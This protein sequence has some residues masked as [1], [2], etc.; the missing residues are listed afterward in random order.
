MPFWWVSE[1]YENLWIADEPAAYTTSLGERIAFRLDYKQRDVRTSQPQKIPAT[2]LH[3]GWFSYVHVRS[4]GGDEAG[5]PF[6]W[7]DATVFAR[8]GGEYYFADWSPVDATTGL[9]LMPM[10]GFS[11]DIYPN[12][13]SPSSANVYGKVGFRLV[14]PD[15]SQDLYGILTPKYEDTIEQ[16]TWVVGTSQG[17]DASLPIRLTNQVPIGAACDALLSEH[18]DPNGNSIHFIYTNDAAQN[19]LLSAVVDYD[20]LTTSLSYANVAGTNLLTQVEMPYGRTVTISY[21]D[22]IKIYDA[23]GMH[24]TITYGSDGYVNSL[25]TPYGLTSFSYI[26]HKG[27]QAGLDVGNAGATNR[28]SRAVLVTHPDNSQELFAYRWDS[29][30]AG[31]AEHMPYP[32]DTPLS[33]LD[34]GYDTDTNAPAACYYRNTFHWD[35]KQFAASAGPTN[36]DYAHWTATNYAYAAVKHWLLTTNKPGFT[37][38]RMYVGTYRVSSAL[39]W[40]REASPSGTTNQPGQMVWYDYFDKDPDATWRI[41]PSSQ[42]LGSARLLPDGSSRYRQI[43]YDFMYLPSTWS[44]T[45]TLPG[46]TRGVR[47]T[48]YTRDFPYASETCVPFSGNVTNTAAATTLSWPIAML[49]AVTGPDSQTLLALS[50]QLDYITNTV[51]RSADNTNYLFTTVYPHRLRV[52]ITDAAGN[53]ATVW[54][55]SQGRVTGV[56]LPNGLTQT[57]K[58]LFRFRQRT[59]GPQR[60]EHGPGRRQPKLFPHK[61]PGLHQRP[62]LAGHQRTWPGPQ[63]QLGQPRTAHESR[64]PARYR[65]AHCK[66]VRQAGPGRAAG[67]QGQF[68]VGQLQCFG[69][70]RLVHRQAGHRAHDSRL[71]QLRWPQFHHR[72][73]RR[74]DQLRARQ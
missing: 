58:Y 14:Y 48:A 23:E 1:P 4:T 63:V 35:R 3:H 42:L 68:L 46:G 73:G 72:P 69:P 22:G 38:D 41:F 20:G 28:I 67:S 51:L 31:L 17:D 21:E 54:S 65:P 34:T 49:S 56:Q 55:D 10:D 66:H 26:D 8:D 57:N 7:W 11:T 45:Y 61:H 37:S 18:V 27:V 50:S 47:T 33:T 59:Q 16:V 43:G 30:Q 39:S 53:R 15:G 70:T 13:N 36:T 6:A 64:V 19:F 62:A 12:T 5:I 71:V 52:D 2:G 40:S 29:E 60:G 74:P 25:E 44:S 24:S 9:Q 32:G